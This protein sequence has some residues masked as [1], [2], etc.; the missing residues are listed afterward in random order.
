[1]TP[2]L[3]LTFAHLRIVPKPPPQDLI[4]C[5]ACQ[6]RFAGSTEGE[7]LAKLRAHVERAHPECLNGGNAA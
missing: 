1:M 6:S 4:H 3:P 5:W 2:Q 7:L